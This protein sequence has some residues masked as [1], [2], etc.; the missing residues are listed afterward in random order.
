MN[1]LECTSYKRLAYLFIII[2]VLFALDSYL[3][4]NFVYKLWPLLILLLG[5]GLTGIYVQS[6]TRGTLYLSAGVYLICFSLLA[7]Y[8]NFTTWAILGRFWPLFITSLG[9]VFIV[10]YMVNRKRRFL[11]FAGLLLL[12]L[13]IYFMLVFSV[14]GQYWWSIFIFLGLSLFLS[15]KNR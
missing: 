3:G 14:S 1:E 5:T 12:F 13:S 6:N 7:L 4:M 11:L 10:L 8:C 15:V 2:G 9:L